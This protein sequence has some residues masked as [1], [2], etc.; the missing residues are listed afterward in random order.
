[1]VL[2]P[3]A[4]LAAAVVL[5]PTGRLGPPDSMPWMNQLVYD[6]NDVAA[7][8]L[9]GLNATL[10]RHAGRDDVPERVEADQ[11]AAALSE[12][13]RLAPR[14][15]LEYPHAALLL[16]RIPYLFGPDLPPAP[17]ALLDGAHEDLVK[18][19]P[20]AARAPLWSRFHAF[21]VAFMVEVIVLYACLAGVLAVGYESGGGLAYRGLLL[22]LPGVL[23]FSL[24]RFDVVPALLTALSFACLGRDR[25][26]LSAAFLAAGTLIK[27][28][29]VFLAPLVLR[30]IH[31][32]RPRSA[33][34]WVTFYAG[35]L[36][37]FLTPAT[38]LWGADEVWAPYL[39]Q[40]SRQHEG[41]TAYQYL[42]PFDGL[43]E[44]LAGNGAVGQLFRPG[45]LAIV[46]AL[47]LMR[48]ASGLDGVLRRGTVVLITFIM[49]SVF[50]SPQWILWLTP[51]LYPLAGRQRRLVPLIVLMDL[52]T[53][54]QWP[55]GAN[56]ARVFELEPFTRDVILTILAFARFGAF[57]LIVRSVLQDERLT[58]AA[59][60]TPALA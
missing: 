20:D 13:R 5:R 46:M 27:V 19:V 28:Y 55:V 51:L 2:V 24:N 43:R 44:E 16:F 40:L 57:A 39:V 22:I 35:T 47:M 26:R 10:G 45:T 8:A 6:D 49:L 11:Y 29:P 33:V 1:M 21:A 50:H 36:L 59:E 15:Y 52:A 60:P 14:Y 23:F 38:W 41:M 25:V 30:Y 3:A 7:Y 58:V 31:A 12:D 37:A 17:A 42:I 54:G 4:C 9:R 53:W 56:L 18:Y 32:N 34:P 48:P